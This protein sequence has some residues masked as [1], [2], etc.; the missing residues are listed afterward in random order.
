MLLPLLA[1]LLIGVVLGL[2]GSGGSIITVPVLMYFLGRPEKQAI[3]E[4]LAIV[5]CV[6]L[7]GAIPYIILGRV[8]WKTVIFF[9]LPGMAGACIGG[10]CTYIISSSLQM[11]LF[12]SVMLVAAGAMLFGS[13][14]Q[15]IPPKSFNQSMWLIILEGFVVGCLTGLL[16]VGGGFAI[17]PALVILCQ[18]PISHA[19]GTSLMIIAMNST[20]GF[21]F[22]FFSLKA[23]EIH[24]DWSIIKMIAVIG[25]VGSFSAGWI[26]QKIPQVYLRKAFGSMLLM[27]SLYVLFS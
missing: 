18:L 23:L 16:G 7:A 11:L 12:A 3:A 19:I 2:L 25:V 13:S 5:G 27:L 4:A 6:A 1:S 22:Q 20:V 17:V 10:C 24:V 8:Q 9:G 26:G 14:S 21:I 15:V